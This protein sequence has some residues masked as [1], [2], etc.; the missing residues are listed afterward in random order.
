MAKQKGYDFKETEPRLIQLW[1]DKKIYKFDSSDIKKEV[2]SF[3]TPPPTVSGKLHMGHV[4]GDAQQDFIARYKRM[5]GFNVLNPFGTDDNGLPTL[6]LIEKE[7]GIKAKDMTRKQFIEIC[8]KAI[9]E[10]YV[11]E[12]LKDAKRLGTSA[13]WD[14]FYSTIDERSRRISQKSFIDLYKQG[15]EY[16][17]KCPSLWCTTCQ[18]TISQVELED[19]SKQ[20]QFNDITFKLE[21]GTD[22]TIATTRP[23]LL[24]A[25]VSI[26]VN[27]KDSR[28]EKLVGKKATVPLFNFQVPILTDEKADPEKGSG[29]VMC[30]TFGD[31]T[32][33]EWQKEHKLEIKEAI[34]SDGKM[35]KLAGKYEGLKIKEARKQIL[36]D[37]K[38][39]NFLTKQETI[40]HDVNVHERCQ[41]P[42][43]FI[44]S[45][46][47]FVKY[48]DIKDD[49]IKWGNEIK[50]HPDYMKH[51]YTNWVKGLKWD[52]CISRQIPFGIPFPVWYCKECDEPIMAEEKDLPIDPLEDSP[53]VSKCPK[54]GCKEFTPETDIMNTWATSSLT[55]DITKDILKGTP[56][57]EKIKDKPFSIR[58]NGHDIITFW[59]FNTVVKSQLHHKRNPWNELMINGWI[60]GKDG[61]KMSKS[62]KNGISPQDTI[63]EH[64]ADALRYLCAAAKLGDDIAFPEAELI[65]AKKLINKL[66]NAAKFVFMNLEDYDGK[67]KPKKLEAV[68]EEFLRHLDHLVGMVTESFE[69]YQYSVAKSRTE[70]FFWDDFADNYIEIVKKRVY[71]GSGDAR[72]SAQYTLYKTILTLSKLFAPIIP[73]IT[74]E[75]YQ[76]YFIKNEGDF[77]IHIS[78]WPEFKKEVQP[79][80]R[81][82]AFCSLLS[83]VRQAKTT[84]Q[85]AMNSE[86][87]LTLDKEYIDMLDEML[88]D[89]KAVTNA[90]KVKEGEFKVEFL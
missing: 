50:W 42:I 20:T 43:E 5:N 59:D 26:F 23:E 48:L 61:K 69:K 36:E 22:I 78:S 24:P 10:E 9:K 46:Q 13:D 68:D 53:P 15:R 32:D 28:Y 87:I 18:T 70:R 64:G 34:G 7:K 80:A 57:Y 16:R 4:F 44:N 90:T 89:L 82:T 39:A 11:P 47:W 31:Q 25:C 35:T 54:C 65:K 86:I 81:F 76:T 62:R 30:C 3:D 6:R 72:L 63:E 75:I 85:K 1:Q 41:T 45:K 79:S 14:I 37:L 38:K 33:M 49:L 74:E 17:I 67:A 60:L 19:E 12:F 56:V 73:F 51:R 29:A 8:L 40:T 66:W 2:F 77:S 27:P 88:E 71:Q 21:D 84:A 58:R 55:P 52:W 83:S